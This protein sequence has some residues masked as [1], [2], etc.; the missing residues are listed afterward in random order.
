MRL[1]GPARRRGWWDAYDGVALTAE[2]K[3]FIGLEQGAD[4]MRSFQPLVV[5]GLLQT[6]MCREMVMMATSLTREPPERMKVLIDMEFG[7][8]DDLGL[9]YVEAVG[10]RP[11]YLGALADVWTYAGLWDRLTALALSPDESLQMLR[12]TVERS[13]PPHG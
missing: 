2:S 6:P 4:R 10:R 11:T 13:T 9:V 8:P 7:W 1:L 3:W 12:D 5:P